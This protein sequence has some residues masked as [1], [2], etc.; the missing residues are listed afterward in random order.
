MAERRNQENKREMLQLR[1][2][3]QSVESNLD[4]KDSKQQDRLTA[5]VKS[6]ETQVKKMVKEGDDR[7]TKLIGLIS[8]LQR[9]QDF[10]EEKFREID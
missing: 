8:P 2:H 5:H 6:Y 4:E 3:I 10:S 9:H 1:Q 7:W